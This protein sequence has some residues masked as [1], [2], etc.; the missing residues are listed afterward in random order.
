[1][2]KAAHLAGVVLN[3]ESGDR[4]AEVAVEPLGRLDRINHPPGEGWEPRH[5]VVAGADAELALEALGPVLCAH[6][7]A[8]VQDGLQRTV[9]SGEFRP[10]R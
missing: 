4:Q 2:R 6:L 3:K 8:V 7:V 5:D 10:K 9:G 1:M